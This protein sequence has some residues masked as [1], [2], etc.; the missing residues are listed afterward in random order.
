MIATGMPVAMPDSALHREIADIFVIHT[1][2]REG[3]DCLER[4]IYAMESFGARLT[5]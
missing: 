3:A 4:G 5:E 2:D 1:S